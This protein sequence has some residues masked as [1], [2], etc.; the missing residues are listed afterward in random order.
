LLGPLNEPA[1][2]EGARGEVEVHASIVA[3]ALSVVRLRQSIT[4]FLQQG[5]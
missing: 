5:A 3:P 2:R 1:A 4:G